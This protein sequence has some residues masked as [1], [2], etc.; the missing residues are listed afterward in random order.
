MKTLAQI[1]NPVLPDNLGQGGSEAGP[2]AVGQL[3]S[4]F[5]GAFFVFA[6][7]MALFYLLLGG[8]NWITAGGDKTRLQGARDEITNAL[9]GLIVVGAGWAIMMLVGD[10]LGIQFPNL[11]LPTIGG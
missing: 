7:V 3:I 9:V 5:I 4:G 6:F 10:F 1:V 2:P 11:E 8:F